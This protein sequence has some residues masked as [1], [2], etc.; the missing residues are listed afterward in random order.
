[1]SPTLTTGAVGGTYTQSLIASGG[2][3]PY[4]WGSSGQLPLGLVLD[5]AAGVIQGTPA[6]I[7]SW[8]FML[9]VTDSSG[10]STARSFTIFIIAAP[11][12]FTVSSLP[13]GAIGV[14]YVQQ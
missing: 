7:G 8:H 14:P 9:R 1:M 4:T 13:D 12:R 6:L 3:P 11:L 10:N 2:T 5:G